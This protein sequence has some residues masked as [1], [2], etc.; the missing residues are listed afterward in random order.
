MGWY[1][2]WTNPVLEGRKPQPLQVIKCQSL[3]LGATFDFYQVQAPGKA[4]EL[5]PPL[6]SSIVHRKHIVS[7]GVDWLI[8]VCVYLSLE[9]GVTFAAFCVLLLVVLI[10]LCGH[11]RAGRGD[12]PTPKGFFKPYAW[13]LL[14]ALVA[15]LVP[16]GFLTGSAAHCLWPQ[17]RIEYKGPVSLPDPNQGLNQYLAFALG[18]GSLS[19][20][21]CTTNNLAFYIRFPASCVRVGEP[22]GE[23]Q[24]D[25][26]KAASE[27]DAHPCSEGNK[28][29]LVFCLVQRGIGT[30]VVLL[31]VA[32][33]GYRAI[34]RKVRS[35]NITLSKP[36][37][38][39]VSSTRE[40]EAD[41]V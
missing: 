20:Q 1:S 4:C 38:T 16:V 18:E 10:V 32:V 13:A 41:A 39:P 26:P 40:D 28:E 8:Y 21:L 37:V 19:L 12:E 7:A 15:S 33:V 9:W 23:L 2:N 22:Y 25:L 29:L 6:V 34:M 14:A 31:I 27:H 5:P 24:P 3:P 35:L 11:I 17:T 30:G 36:R